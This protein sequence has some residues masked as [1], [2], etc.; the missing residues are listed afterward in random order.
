MSR[1][2]N[3]FDLEEDGSVARSDLALRFREV[4]SMT[5]WTDDQVDQI[6][7]MQPGESVNFDGIKVERLQ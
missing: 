2:Y 5:D 4:Q 3:M 1:L 6:C 7:D